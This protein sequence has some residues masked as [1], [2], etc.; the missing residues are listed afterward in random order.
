MYGL[1]YGWY[2]C[3]KEG[4][5]SHYLSLGKYEIQIVDQDKTLKIDDEVFYTGDM[6]NIEGKG[7]VTEIEKGN[8]RI[9]LEDDRELYVF[10][11]SFTGREQTKR[12]WLLEE[13]REYRFRAMML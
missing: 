13:Y 10:L 4:E 11:R 5:P 12:F 6:A 9:K 3:T 7:T 2:P 1:N 8:A